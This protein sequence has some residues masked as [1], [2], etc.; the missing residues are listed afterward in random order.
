M[1]CNVIY[2]IP[3]KYLPPDQSKQAFAVPVEKHNNKTAED[4]MLAEISARLHTDHTRLA[5]P[6]YQSSLRRISETRSTRLEAD[7]AHARARLYVTHA[8]AVLPPPTPMRDFILR[9]LCCLPTSLPG[10]TCL[11]F[12]P[13]PP[14][15]P[16][17][18]SGQPPPHALRLL[19][20]LLPSAFRGQEV[21]GHLRPA[22]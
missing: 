1:V 13:P 22:L 4:C 14:P 9:G 19:L 6:D 18:P 21:R 20:P 5:I 10:D 12:P 7:H 8:P 11:D 17:R 16:H 15:L 3:S 2:S